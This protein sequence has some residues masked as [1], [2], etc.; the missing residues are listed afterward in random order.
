[1]NINLNVFKDIVC[2]N[3]LRDIKYAYKEWVSKDRWVALYNG[4]RTRIIL[5]AKRGNS[6]YA[7]RNK[8]RFNGF[9][10]DLPDDYQ[11]FD[12][13]AHEQKTSVLWL[14]LTIDPN[15]NTLENSWL[16]LAKKYNL[17]ITK[18]RQTY[19]HITSVMV[20]E[21]QKSGYP[22]LHVILNF[23]EKRFTAFRLNRTHRIDDINRQIIKSMWEHGFSDI[24]ACHSFQAFSYLTKYITKTWETCDADCISLAMLWHYNK[25][26]YSISKNY[27]YDLILL[28]HNSK[29]TPN[30]NGVI[31]EWYCMFV[32]DSLAEADSWAT[33]IT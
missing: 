23:K 14:T 26:A 32:A 10:K 9:L 30:Y 6:V 21:A 4:Q 18:M 13:N 5:S 24:V 17:F 1:M 29:I 8:E 2:D 19:G 25:R 22:H 27:F 3:K 7:N 20:T 16:T 11:I 15:N 12:K 33:S 31:K 28:K